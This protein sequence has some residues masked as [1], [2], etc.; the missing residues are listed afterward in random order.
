M[1]RPG[2]RCRRCISGGTPVLGRGL[3]FFFSFPS[4]SDK[5]LFLFFPAL[6]ATV[7]NQYTS[8][9]FI[10]SS[11]PSNTQQSATQVILFSTRTWHFFFPTFPRRPQCAPVTAQAGVAGS[12]W[13]GRKGGVE[14][15]K[16]K[17]K[18]RKKN[19]HRNE[20]KTIK[21]K[22]G[23]GDPAFLILLEAFCDTWETREKK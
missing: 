14:N 18:K 22:R 6:T 17:K 13:N 23:C 12:G 9:H 7:P 2:P 4:I 10:T 19:S 16:R 5:V 20:I 15:E 3:F 21:R 11:F 1:R 8:I